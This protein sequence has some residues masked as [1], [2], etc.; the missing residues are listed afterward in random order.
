MNGYREAQILGELVPGVEGILD[1]LSSF[2]EEVGPEAKFTSE[3]GRALIDIQDR[4]RSLLVEARENLPEGS[5]SRNAVE[6]MWDDGYRFDPGLTDMTRPDWNQFKR[7][8]SEV[9][10]GLRNLR[11]FRDRLL[12]HL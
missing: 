10:N 12:R 2:E 3:Q 8:K 5:R 9:E 4:Y 1:E 11:D 6:T 7:F